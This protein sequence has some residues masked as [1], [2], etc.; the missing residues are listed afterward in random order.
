MESMLTKNR[1]NAV[2]GDAAPSFAWQHLMGPFATAFAYYV[3]AV[4][5]SALAFPAA[6]V[7]AFWAPNALLMAALLL[8]PPQRWWIYLLA[9]APFHVLAQLSTTAP[10][11]I[12]IQ[13][14]LNCAEALIGA[15]AL[16]HRRP[17]R[18]VGTPPRRPATTRRV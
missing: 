5:G 18:R 12:L 6:P 14:V 9:I 16:V 11:Q 7:S 1:W 4:L 3:A 10:V 2:T 13:Y 8:A 17:P 15:A